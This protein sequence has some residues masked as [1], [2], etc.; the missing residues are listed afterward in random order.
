MDQS[1]IIN[2]DTMTT[3]SFIFFPK[4]TEYLLFLIEKLK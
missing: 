4:Q 2:F 3:A 1:K